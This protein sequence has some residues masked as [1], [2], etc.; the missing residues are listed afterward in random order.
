MKKDLRIAFLGLGLLLGG[1][2]LYLYL[3]KGRQAVSRA[4]VEAGM[5]RQQQAAEKMARLPG[6]AILQNYAL[7]HTRPQEDLDSLSH[8]FSNL[9]LLIKGDAP[10]HLGANEEFAA[11]LRGKNRT[12]LP[13]VSAGH[14]AFN[15]LGQLVDR[16]G[17][18][19]HF[20]VES[21]D[22]IEI[23]SAGP[24]RQM[25]TE[26]DLHRRHDGTYLKG[27]SLNPPSLHKEP[28]PGKGR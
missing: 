16:W 17:S 15:S 27:E 10:F 7:P 1:L 13:F 3:Q 8:T 5:K 19:L 20:H 4:I 18:P 24:D 28:A 25:W 21:H 12:Q 11:A 14:P 22:R 23:R 26:D 9:F 6:D 2:V